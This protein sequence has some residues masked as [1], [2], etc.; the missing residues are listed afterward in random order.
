MRSRKLNGSKGGPPDPGESGGTA[1]P[2][3]VRFIFPRS[4]SDD[5]LQKVV[6][7]IN[8]MRRERL[9]GKDKPHIRE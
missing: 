7:A 8:K 6:D 2:R 4:P 3:L 5:D 1:K 9:A